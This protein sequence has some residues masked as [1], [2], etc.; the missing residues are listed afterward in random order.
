MTAQEFINLS[1]S[2]WQTTLETLTGAARRELEGDVTAYAQRA[3]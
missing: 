1:P 2:E 3:A